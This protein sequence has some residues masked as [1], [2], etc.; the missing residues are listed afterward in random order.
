MRATI[1]IFI[2]VLWWCIT[3]RKD[4]KYCT[5]QYRKYDKWLLKWSFFFHFFF[6]LLSFSFYIWIFIT[7]LVNLDEPP[8]KCILRNSLVW[9]RWFLKVL[10]FVC[11]VECIG[12]IKKR[13]TFPVISIYFLIWILVLIALLNYSRVKVYIQKNWPNSFIYSIKFIYIFYANDL[14]MY[15]KKDEKISLR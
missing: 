13:F 15:V 14:K 6:F 3:K 4:Q 2:C 8:F 12:G 10:V 9:N 1:F 11:I 7:F 5:I